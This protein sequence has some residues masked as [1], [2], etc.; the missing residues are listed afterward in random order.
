[1]QMMLIAPLNV[2]LGS[3][4]TRHFGG[5]YSMGI[6]VAKFCGCVGTNLRQEYA[7]IGSTVNLAAKL[8]AKRLIKMVCIA[9]AQRAT[10]LTKQ[11]FHLLPKGRFQ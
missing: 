7:I 9:I 8:M 5:K 11:N 2:A 3:E 10:R 6:S 4:D 1:M